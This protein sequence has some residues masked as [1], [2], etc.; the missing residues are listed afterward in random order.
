MEPFETGTN[1]TKRAKPMDEAMFFS[2]TNQGFPLASC[3]LTLNSVSFSFVLLLQVILLLQVTV[4]AHKTE[5]LTSV[6]AP[7]NPPSRN[8]SSSHHSHLSAGLLPIQSKSH[9][10]PHTLTTNKYAS[11]PPQNPTPRPPSSP[12]P[13]NNPYHCRSR[14]RQR[15]GYQH[16]PKRSD[17]MFHAMQLDVR[18]VRDA[19]W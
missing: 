10:P 2:S 15:H 6:S 4:A 3:N 18:A 7:F 9:N 1:A 19:C 11:P 13:H 12:R 17:R 14:D 16:A 5:C 8:T